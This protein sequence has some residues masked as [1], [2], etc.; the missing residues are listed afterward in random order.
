MISA[1]GQ[2]LFTITVSIYLLTDVDLLNPRR[3]FRLERFKKYQ[4]YEHK[5]SFSL[6]LLAVQALENLP[7]SL[8][9]L[10]CIHKTDHYSEKICKLEMLNICTHVAKH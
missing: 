6:S 10:Y 4:L 5:M 3:N 8:H 9:T 2:L 1:A 7:C